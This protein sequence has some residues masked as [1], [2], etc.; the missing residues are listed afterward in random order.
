MPQREVKPSRASATGA[1]AQLREEVQEYH[2]EVRTTLA[3]MLANCEHCRRQVQ[4]L[5]LQLNGCKPESDAAPGLRKDVA[6]LKQS[7]DGARRAVRTIW[8][9]IG[10]I[11]AFV[12]AVIAWFSPK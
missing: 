6:S 8:V 9:A 11:T 7:R 10:G 12:S 5:D 1:V 3:T 4:D 2:L